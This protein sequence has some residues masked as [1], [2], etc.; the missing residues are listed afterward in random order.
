MPYNP[1]VQDMSGQIL[2]QGISQF[3]QGVGGG[4]A[5]AGKRYD[6]NKVLSGQVK[7]LETLLPLYAQHTGATPEEIEKFLA[8]SPDESARQRAARLSQTVEGIIGAAAMKSRGLNDE[9]VRTNTAGAQQ[10]QQIAAANRRDQVAQRGRVRGIYGGQP[11]REEIEAMI[12]TGSQF[13]DLG[14]GTPPANGAAGVQQML[15]A[16]VDDPRLLAAVDR[17]LANEEFKPR[18]VDMGGG[19]TAMMTSRNSAVPLNRGASKAVPGA[20]GVRT[21]EL[22]GVGS[23]VVDAQTGE[24]IPANRVVR[25]QASGGKI[26]PMLV[27]TLTQQIARL[28]A[29]KLQHQQEIVGGDERTGFLNLSSRKDRLKEIE[30]QLEGLKATL[31]AGGKASADTTAAAQPAPAAAKPI[32]SPYN[33][34][35]LQAE[36]RRRGLI[37]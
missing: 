17:I 25:P 11:S 28:E 19:V 31:K 7:A 4:I 21:I 37:Q 24:P 5:A 20:G 26:D 36:L 1:G 29:E 23:M 35:D 2:A 3:A 13:E 32:P 33:S 14:A 15:A 16:G 18:M 12:Q 10:A 30:Q 6:E 34:A 27:G 9:L 22:P 8:P